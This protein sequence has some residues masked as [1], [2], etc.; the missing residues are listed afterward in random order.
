MREHVAIRVAVTSMMI[1]VALLVIAYRG[2]ER[3][4][5]HDPAAVELTTTSVRF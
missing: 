4:C 3:C 5:T 2:M 1:G